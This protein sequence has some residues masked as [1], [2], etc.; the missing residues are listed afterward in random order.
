M[1]YLIILFSGLLFFS[2]KGEDTVA[3]VEPV[4]EYTKVLTVD[5]ANYK[6]ELYSATGSSLL[7]G[8]NELGIKVF[9]NNVEKTDGFVR[10]IPSMFHTGDQ[11]HKTPHKEFFYYD[12]Q[13]KMFTGYACYIMIS[14]PTS[15]WISDYS[16]ND[17]FTLKRK[18][19]DVYPNPASQMRFWLDL[20]TNYLYLMI[21]INPADPK[22]GLNNFKCILHRSFE[23]SVY[24][25]VDSAKMFIRPWMPSHGHGSS[26]NV[27]PVLLQNGIYEG[28]ANFTMAGTW[29]VYDSI[30]VNNQII[31][32]NPPV[33]FVFDVR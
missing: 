27:N 17:A 14:D 19:F 31:T 9:E 10:Y 16:Y 4:T 6:F 20:N 13:K 26:S 1:K 25:E 12:Q 3:P 24:A 18:F 11:E 21:L 30:S 5:S 15:F 7:V 28:K 8:Y 2:C 33:Y 22:T 29:Y 23:N 32:P